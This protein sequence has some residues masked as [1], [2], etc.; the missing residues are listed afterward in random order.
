MSEKLA[1]HTR[2]SA[3]HTARAA[4]QSRGVEY[5]AEAANHLIPIPVPPEMQDG[6]KA[7][8]YLAAAGADC[9]E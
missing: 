1:A 7:K 5:T 2:S 9:R 8:L 3:A 6:A 4:G